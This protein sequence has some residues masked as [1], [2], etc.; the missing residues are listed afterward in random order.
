M[1][2]GCQGRRCLAPGISFMTRVVS[3]RT[4]VTIAVRMGEGSWRSFLEPQQRGQGWSA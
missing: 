4:K 3:P 2:S 1:A